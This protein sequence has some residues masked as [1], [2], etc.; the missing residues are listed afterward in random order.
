MSR[1]LSLKNAHVFGMAFI[2]FILTCC[3]LPVSA[4]END[5]GNSIESGFKKEK[6]QSFIAATSTRFNLPTKMA[7]PTG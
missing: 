6:Y 4:R 7:N 1:I 3:A 2:F 5:R